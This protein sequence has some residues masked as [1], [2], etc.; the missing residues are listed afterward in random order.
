MVRKR[1]LLRFKGRRDFLLPAVLLVFFFVKQSESV[2]HRRV[3][4]REQHGVFHRGAISMFMRRPGR[5]R[6][7]VAFAPIELFAIDDRRAF[8]FDDV[9]DRAAGVAMGFGV[10]VWPEHLRAARHRRH[11]RAAGLRVAVFQ[12]DAVE[13]AAV[14]MAQCSERS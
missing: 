14:V 5:Q 2:Q 1:T 8:A 3:L 9:V 6:Y 4:D 13:R 7:D 12:R 10:F 11:H